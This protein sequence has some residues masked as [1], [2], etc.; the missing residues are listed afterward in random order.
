MN[1]PRLPSLRSKPKLGYGDAGVKK[2]HIGFG[3]AFLIFGAA[4][5]LLADSVHHRSS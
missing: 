5:P 1:C 3:A 4:G 2:I